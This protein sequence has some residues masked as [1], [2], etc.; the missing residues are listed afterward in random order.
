MTRL[1]SFI[2]FF[3]IGAAAKAQVKIHSHNDYLKPR[4]LYT[5]LESKAFSIEADV[6]LTKHGLLVAHSLKE[7]NRK[8]TLSALYIDPII[9][10]FKKHHGKISADTAY[11]PTL[12][13]DIKQN[14]Q[15]VLAELV[16]M[17]KPLRNYFDRSLNPHAVQL[18]IS[19]DRGPSTSWK[20]YPSYIYFDG[21]PYEEYEPDTIEKI[22]MISD[23]YFNY[24]LARNNKADTSKIRATV[25]KA[26]NW[27]KPFR[28]WASPDSESVW[29]LLHDTGADIINTDKPAACREFFDKLKSERPTAQ[30]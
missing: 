20:N 25:Q 29:K 5:A 10:L 30:R 2:L 27:N 28:F 19:G 1:L 11:K 26:H 23:N 13:I 21:R 6:F 18:I 4:P 24:L 22:G 7:T 15:E 12:V 17:F 8:K 14:G 9:A 3:I 16:R